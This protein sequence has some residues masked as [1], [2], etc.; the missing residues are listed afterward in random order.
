MREEGFEPSQALSH[1]ILSP[2]QLTRLCDSR[3]H[4]GREK[5][6]I[7]VLSLF[8]LRGVEVF[9]GSE[10]LAVCRSRVRE[11]EMTPSFQSLEEVVR[12][13]AAQYQFLLLL[14]Q[15]VLGCREEAV[16]A[17][18]RRDHAHAE[19]VFFLYL[20]C[21]VETLAFLYLKI[22]SLQRIVSFL[23]KKIRAVLSAAGR[24]SQ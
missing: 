5:S 22:S 24:S 2:A 17:L 7:N 16:I 1:R 13:E 6:L 11:R 12:K 21:R 8:I 3:V 9:L 18:V 14:L 15:A 19:R 4:R 10:M 23:R 20:P